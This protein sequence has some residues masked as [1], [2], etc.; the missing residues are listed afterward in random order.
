MSA[1]EC[2]EANA[3]NILLHGDLSDLGWGLV[4]ARV[5]DLTSGVAQRSGYNLGATI[6]AV[7]SR[8]CDQNPYRHHESW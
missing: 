8:F 5:D 2:G 7:K 4:E 6:M 1:R 3:I